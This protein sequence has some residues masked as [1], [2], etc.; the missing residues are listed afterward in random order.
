LKLKEEESGG[1]FKAR[2]EG[3]PTKKKIPA[4]AAAHCGI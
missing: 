3:N 2:T 4:E 1:F